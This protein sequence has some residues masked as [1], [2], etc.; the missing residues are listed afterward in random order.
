MML[1][2]IPR[3]ED[4]A[5]GSCVLHRA[6]PLWELGAILERLERALRV[7][8]VVRDMWATV[9]FGNAQISQHQTIL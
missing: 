8:I 6:E 9:G 4:L 1:S 7:W 2:V 5:E 3:E